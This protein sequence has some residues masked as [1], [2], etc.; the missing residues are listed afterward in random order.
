VEKANESGPVKDL[1]E[2]GI[3]ISRLARRGAHHLDLF[4]YARADI[5]ADSAIR[6]QRASARETPLRSAI[7]ALEGVESE[8]KGAQGTQDSC[9]YTWG[10][11]SDTQ[12]E[13]IFL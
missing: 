2:Q 6:Y 13:T 4:A 7:L 11:S 10:P 8:A 5:P 3:T 1:Y 12:L 9:S